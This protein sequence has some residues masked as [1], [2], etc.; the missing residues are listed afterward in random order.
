MNV[1]SIIFPL[2]GLRL[3]VVNPC[4]KGACIASDL[5]LAAF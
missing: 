5:L 2:H 1:L 3:F 4:H